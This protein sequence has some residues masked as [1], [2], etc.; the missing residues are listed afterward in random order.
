[1]VRT[2]QPGEAA[3]RSILPEGRRLEAVRGVSRRR[4]GWRCLLESR[5]SPDLMSL[6]S[7][8]RPV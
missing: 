3:F 4:F 1:M 5:V 8:Y 6:G 2:H 7:R